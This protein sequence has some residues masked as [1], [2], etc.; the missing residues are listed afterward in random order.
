[1]SLNCLVG[2]FDVFDMFTV[3]DVFDVLDVCA[4]TDTNRKTNPGKCKTGSNRA[5]A[6][7][8]PVG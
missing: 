5:E 2:V 3:I 4:H 7:R 6:K 8:S 1:M